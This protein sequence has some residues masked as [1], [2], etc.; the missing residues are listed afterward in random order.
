[1]TLYERWP[2]RPP[3]SLSANIRPCNKFA[4]CLDM[5]LE[6]PPP[7]LYD[8][9]HELVV[10]VKG[11]AGTHGYAAT[12]KNSNEC[13]GFVYL[14]CDCTG[15]RRNTHHIT[16][17]TRRR[18]R[19]SRR[20]NCP[21]LVVGRRSTGIWGLTVRVGHHN[22][23]QTRPDVHPTLRHLNND[24]RRLVSSLTDAGV[25]P[26]QIESH[27]QQTRTTE[28]ELPLITRDI[29]NIRHQLL[30]VSPDGRTPIQA[31]LS[32]FA[33]DDFVWSTGLLHWAM[34]HTCFMPIVIV[35]I[36]LRFILR[37]FFLTVHTRQTG[38]TYHC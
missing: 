3:R 25:K 38:M 1:M 23:G 24:Q 9:R 30:R 5:P 37:F 27:L 14:G 13:K 17:S 29:Y 36:C 16:A 31:L 6:P 19:G 35:F 10:A 28:E 2:S 4:Y 12:V 8:S 22:H 34:P 21:F 18:E 33:A 26:L 7:A 20:N 15:E 11:W 32:Q